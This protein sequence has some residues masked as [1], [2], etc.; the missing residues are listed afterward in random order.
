MYNVDLVITGTETVTMRY[1]SKVSAIEAASA[2]TRALA[3]YE[4]SRNA[5]G[6]PFTTELVSINVTKEG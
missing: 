3:D 4:P 1:A 6:D 2:V 5:A